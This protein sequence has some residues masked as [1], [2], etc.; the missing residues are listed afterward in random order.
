MNQPPLKGEDLIRIMV[1]QDT[2]PQKFNTEHSGGLFINLF[3]FIKRIMGFSRLSFSSATALFSK[4][5]NSAA[6]P[7]GEDNSVLAM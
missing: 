6:K 3:T 7:S 5:E 4:W 1:L 2:E